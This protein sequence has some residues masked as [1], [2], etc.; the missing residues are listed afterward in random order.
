MS[1]TNHLCAISVLRGIVTI[2]YLIRWVILLVTHPKGS[3]THWC[4]LR[5][6][7]FSSVPQLCPNLC[8]PMDFSMSGFP[9]HHQ[10]P[11]FTQTQVHWVD[12]AM[13]PSHPLSSPSPPAFSLTQHQGLFRWVSS[14]HRVAKVLQFQLQHQSFQWIFRTDFILDELVGSPC[15]PGNTQ[16]SSLTPQFKSI[17]SSLLSFLYNPT[18]TSIHDYWKNHSFD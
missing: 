18:L 13:Q 14:S 2:G 10:P 15:T 3:R 1:L 7:L 8:D 5:K 17:S 11:E 9:V 4:K 16:Y 6:C 12:D